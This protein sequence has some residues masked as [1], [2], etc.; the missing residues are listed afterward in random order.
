MQTTNSSG[1]GGASPRDPGAEIYI[2]DDEPM[3]LELATVILEPLGYRVKTFRS[4]ETAVEEFKAAE[5]R[6]ALIITDYAMHN[7]NGMELI[8]ACRRIQPSQK[9]LLLSGTVGPDIYHDLPVKPDRFLAKPYQA[10]QLADA[11]KS[12]L[13]D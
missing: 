5:R 1:R 9:T 7:M 12:M 3:L 6:P 2:V 8:E 10:R 4:P 11:V 13:P